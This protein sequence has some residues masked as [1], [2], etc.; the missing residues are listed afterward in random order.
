MPTSPQSLGRTGEPLTIDQNT[1]EI[2]GTN[3][4]KV[5]GKGTNLQ[6]SLALQQQIQG[7]SAPSVAGRP[8]LY[9]VAPKAEEKPFQPIAGP[10]GQIITPSVATPT[11]LAQRAAGTLPSFNS[12]YQPKLPTAPTVELGREEAKAT[13]LK[14]AAEL[15][16]Q[17]G[18]ESRLYAGDSYDQQ[19]LTQKAALLGSLF[20]ERLTPEDLRFLSPSQQSAIRNADKSAIQAHL[21]SLNSIAQ[22][23]KELR[24]EEQAK[25]DKQYKMMVDSGT[26]IE[27]LPKGFLE[28]MDA[29]AGV[30]SGFYSSIYKAELAKNEQEKMKADL[31]IQTKLVD[32]LSK[33]PEGKSITIGGTTYQGW[34]EGNTLKGT[35]EDANGN[36]TVWTINPDT[37]AVQTYNLGSIGKAQGWTT[38][39]L[40]NGQMWRVNEQTGQKQLLLDP[41]APNGGMPFGG[42]T[43]LFP[44]GTVLTKRGQC[45]E[46]INDL[47]GINVGD[48]FAS[49]MEKMD[50]SISI[51]NAQIGDVVTLRAGSTGHIAIINDIQTDPSGTLIYRLTESNWKAPNTVSNLRTIK[52]TEVQG[53]ARP[54]FIN[55]ALNFGTDSTQ[56]KLVE[57]WADFVNKGGNITAVP[58]Y[59]KNKVITKVSETKTTETPKIDS[60]KDK[61]SLIDSLIK[62]PGLRGSVGPYYLSRFTP[63]TVDKSARK[64]FAAGVNQLI[65]KDT[66]DILINLK[67][68]GGTLGALSDKERILLQNSASKISSWEIQD[69]N[70]N[71]T[72]EYEVNES[73]F[74]KELNR[75]KDLTAKAIINAGGDLNIRVKQ[76]SDGTTGEIPMSEFDPNLYEKL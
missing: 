1:F 11:Q 24:K 43:T 70:G 20:G 8:D 52:A 17:K 41:N 60:L 21:A 44:D 13:A 18:L 65:G 50:K 25:L 69:S 27:N 68:Q 16:A 26:P 66:M 7:G 61:V 14:K 33:I 2:K 37:G 49:K 39:T 74:I 29:S 57:S 10:S 67:A 28:Q 72:G 62:S 6:E 75:I 38:K 23:R 76:K 35:E 55:S 3:T 51:E 45:G 22:G 54:G 46:F 47:T 36:V 73:T 12:A 64:E 15:G 58:E 34:G 19:L 42:L 5:Y 9:A 31:E 63:F 32:A 4:G 48:T 71:P 53:Y 59:L 40:E 30:P 56:S